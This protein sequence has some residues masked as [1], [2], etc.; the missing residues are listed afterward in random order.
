MKTISLTDEAYERLKSWKSP[1]CDS[2]SKVVLEVIPKRGTAADMEK[3]FQSLKPLTEE[4]AKRIEE[5]MGWANSWDNVSDT[6]SSV[7]TGEKHAGCSIAGCQFFDFAVAARRE[8]C[9]CNLA[10]CEWGFGFGHFLGGEGGIF[11]RC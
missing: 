2:F 10:Q 5:A 4:E 8:E 9:R 7:A 1:E 6:W 11:A 3:A